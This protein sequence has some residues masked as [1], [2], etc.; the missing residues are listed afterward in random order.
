LSLNGIFYSIINI[1]D[2]FYDDITIPLIKN[3]GSNILFTIFLYPYISQRILL[4]LSNEKNNTIIFFTIFP[5]LKNVC[6]TVINS[7]KSLNTLI[8]T[9]DDNGYLLDR[10]FI[11]P[12][13][14]VSPS[15]IPFENK[16]LRNFLKSTLNWN[17]IDTAKITPKYNDNIV[18]IID[19]SDNQ[20]LIQIYISQKEKKAVLR[21]NGQKKCEFIVTPNE[22]FLSIDIK[23]TE[24]KIDFFIKFLVNKCDDHLTSFIINISYQIDHNSQIY[25]LLL[26]DKNYAR[27]ITEL[28]KSSTVQ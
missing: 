5:Y 6:N 22:I 27:A 23:T 1:V 15:K 10:L 20:K 8:Y 21:Q 24:R 4:G 13:D 28:N 18:D 2:G 17:W 14:S 3:Y 26:K 19:P 11:W 12:L 16:K 25:K 7:L 9:S